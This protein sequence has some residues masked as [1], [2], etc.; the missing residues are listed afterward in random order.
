[1]AAYF[2]DLPPCAGG[3]HADCQLTRCICLCH[4]STQTLVTRIELVQHNAT[5]VIGQLIAELRRR[6][7]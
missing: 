7:A 5:V 6:D 4:Q 1:M 2:D 3:R